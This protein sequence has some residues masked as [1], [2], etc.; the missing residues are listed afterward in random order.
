MKAETM[1]YLEG[2]YEKL[3]QLKK[4]EKSESWLAAARDGSL[5]VWKEIRLTGLPYAVLKQLPPGP[6]PRVIY[7]AEDGE[8]TLV[9][10]EYIQGES[11]RERLSRK[12]WLTEREARS[13]MLQLCRGLS[14]LHEAGLIHRDIKPSNLILQAGGAVC[15]IDFDAARLMKESGEE[16]TRL[17]GTRG[18]APPE[19]FGYGQT[20]ARSDIYSLGVTMREALPPDYQGYL[21]GILAR[22]TEVDAKRRYGSAQELARAVRYGKYRKPVQLLA[23]A[24][25]LV[26]AALLWLP[27][28]VPT[29][30]EESQD[31]SSQERREPASASQ[32]ESQAPEGQAEKP[33]NVQ[34]PEQ[35]LPA[36]PN[37]PIAPALPAAP[38]PA[39]VAEPARE[40]AAQPK[41]SG[42]ENKSAPPAAEE[43]IYIVIYWNGQKIWHGRNDLDVPINNRGRMISIPKAVWQEWGEEGS[44][45]RFPADWNLSLHVQNASSSPWSQPRLELS[46]DDLGL[47]QGRVLEGGTLQAGEEMSF[48]IP[49]EEYCVNQPWIESP[50]RELHLHL[51]GGGAQQVFNSDYSVS[52]LFEQ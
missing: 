12:E 28:P 49:L 25:T 26:A 24:V 1:A 38:S 33:K 4:T 41:S 40:P 45:V 6:W 11:L 16:D 22:C 9:I 14:H 32:E 8:M 3:R 29:Q 42:E 43:R 7:A 47:R 30:Q 23:A 31:V 21:Q 10:E 35:A 20:E 18:Y 17:L 13:I 2:L 15:V 44:P 37:L 48:N 39:P 34:Q 19:Q 27:G 36:A 52:F 50:S 51:S 46:Y 5:V